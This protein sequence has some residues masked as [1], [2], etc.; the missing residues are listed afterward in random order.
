MCIVSERCV[1]NVCFG[2]GFGIC[3]VVVD[4][5]GRYGV[6]LH[7]RAL[8]GVTLSASE[9]APFCSATFSMNSTPSEM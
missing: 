1:R 8:A 7:A 4:A 3:V 2:C 9:T 5:W 6:H